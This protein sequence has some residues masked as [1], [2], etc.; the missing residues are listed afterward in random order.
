MDTHIYFYPSE[1]PVP[2]PAPAPEP[3]FVVKL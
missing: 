2:A 1:R 3:G